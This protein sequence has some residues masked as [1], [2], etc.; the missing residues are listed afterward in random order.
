MIDV[1][2]G[3]VF[4]DGIEPLPA[5]VELSF[6]VESNGELACEGI[7][8]SGGEI[9]DD[10][11]SQLMRNISKCWDWK[12]ATCNGEPVDFWMRLPLQLCFKKSFFLAIRNTLFSNLIRFQFPLFNLCTLPKQLRISLGLFDGQNMKQKRGGGKC[13]HQ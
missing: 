5:K 3:L 6:I 10:L 12:V 2:D 13:Y 11:A 7:R 8:L 1:T 9:D 4:K